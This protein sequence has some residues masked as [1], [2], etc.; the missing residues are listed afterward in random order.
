MVYIDVVRTDTGGSVQMPTGVSPVIE[1]AS[2]ARA[3]NSTLADAEPWEWWIFNND[4]GRWEAATN[5]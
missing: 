1:V 3:L 4:L 5:Q 2:N